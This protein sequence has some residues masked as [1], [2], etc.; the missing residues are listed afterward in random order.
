MCILYCNITELAHI[1]SEQAGEQYSFLRR[2]SVRLIS[3]F[4]V[5]VE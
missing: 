1:S 2:F 4:C 5:F 3:Q